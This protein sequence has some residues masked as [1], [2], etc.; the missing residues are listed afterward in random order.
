GGDDDETHFDAARSIS[1]P[2]GGI[3]LAHGALVALGELG[4]GHQYFLVAGLGA[5]VAHD[6]VAGAGGWTLG[7][8]ALAGDD[9]DDD[10]AGGRRARVDRLGLPCDPRTALGLYLAEPGDDIDRLRGVGAGGGE[11]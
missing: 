1:R 7:L 6:H 3:R 8:L 4:G 5:A 11:E 10:L 9:R 2:A